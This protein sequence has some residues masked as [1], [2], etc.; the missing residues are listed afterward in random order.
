M[1]GTNGIDIDIVSCSVY[2]HCCKILNTIGRNSRKYMNV[3]I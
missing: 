2:K 3:G 1:H